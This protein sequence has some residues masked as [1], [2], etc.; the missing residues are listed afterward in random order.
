MKRLDEAQRELA[1]AH[2]WLAEKLAH[3]FAR[4]CPRLFD[5]ALSAAMLGLCDA[6]L[7]YAPDR[8][9]RFKSFAHR[10]I[11]G[12]M[13]DSARMELPQGFRRQKDA[14]RPALSLDAATETGETLAG[15]VAS[16]E[17]PVGWEIESEDAVNALSRRLPVRH[18]QA[19]RT[20]YTR[21]DGVTHKLTGRLLGVC[22]S[23]VSQMLTDAHK[24]L[25][26]DT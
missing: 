11:V 12:A 8:G 1:A 17:L 5:T 23:R 3:R 21:A 16:G 20:F 6:A 19:L 9:S 4:S 25:R 10:R 26:A 2:V 14:A 7:R 18:A 22:E 15:V 24:A 13:L